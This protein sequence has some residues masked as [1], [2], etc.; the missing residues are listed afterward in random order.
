MAHV[1]KT[2]GA[3]EIEQALRK[4]D[5][6]LGTKIRAGLIRAGRHLQEYSQQVVPVLTS[7]LKNSAG[8][9]DVGSG[10]STDVIVFY[11]ASYAAFV[12]ERTELKHKP[13]KQAKFLEGP[14]RLHRKD[15]LKDIAEE[16]SEAF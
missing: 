10:W 2:V 9:R 7:N 12:H 6:R 16:A 3:K 1:V 11:T 5:H 13:G 15:L 14:A 4:A 8:T